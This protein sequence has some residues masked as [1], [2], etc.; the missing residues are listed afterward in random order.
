[1]AGEEGSGV[2]WLTQEYISSLKSK[3][4]S[5]RSNFKYPESTQ[6]LILPKNQAARL[7]LVQDFFFLPMKCTICHSTWILLST[8]TVHAQKFH[9]SSPASSEDK[10]IKKKWWK[11]FF[12]EK[13][14]RFLFLNGMSWF[15]C[16]FWISSLQT[17][18]QKEQGTS[19]STSLRE[20]S[21][22]KL[23]LNLRR[24]KFIP[25]LC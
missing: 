23:K 11:C 6:A 22:C 9:F 13:V 18:E 20:W 2:S 8:L 19:W 3:V 16:A 17:L 25:H 14:C 7:F 21:S 12:S 15:F 4:V 10:K 1:M 5:Y 24:E